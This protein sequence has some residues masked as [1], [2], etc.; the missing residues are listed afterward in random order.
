MATAG[1]ATNPARSLPSPTVLRILPLATSTSLR[2]GVVMSSGQ[3]QHSP[4]IRQRKNPAWQLAWQFDRFPGR[5]YLPSLRQYRRRKALRGPQAAPT[6][7][8][9]PAAV[10]LRN[11]ASLLSERITPPCLSDIPAVVAAWPHCL[12]LSCPT[13]VYFK[14]VATAFLPD[15]AVINCADA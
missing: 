9:Q 14:R 11:S 5:S 1:P 8:R 4:S 12:V 3:D 13:K 6:P 2:K 10:T 7:R 15:D